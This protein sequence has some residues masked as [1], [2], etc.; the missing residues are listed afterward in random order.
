MKLNISTSRISM[1]VGMLSAACLMFI[2]CDP[3]FSQ[4]LEVSSR[5]ITVVEV[6]APENATISIA[7]YG[8]DFKP[9]EVVKSSDRSSSK[10][11]FVIR[12]YEVRSSGKSLV[13]VSAW[14]AATGWSQQT[15]LRV[16]AG[17]GPNPPPDPPGPGPD[18][19][20][21]PDPPTPDPD[22]PTPSDYSGP[23]KWGLGKL[24]FENAPENNKTVT[25]IYKDAAGYARGH[26]EVKAITVESGHP[27]A[28]T[29]KIISI[30]I[31]DKMNPVASADSRWVDWYT[32]VHEKLDELAKAKKI[33]FTTD[34]YEAFFEIA[35]GVEAKK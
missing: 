13:I 29:D 19:D 20:P 5:R 25:S 4:S 30:W 14:D 17:N 7:A 15:D 8:P 22:P 28:G 9:V 10:S 35:S 26:P 6:D 18:P 2:S 12:V 16:D 1:R 24:S 23:N 21:D 27:W 31:G 3:C 33:R 34:Y 32:K 11:D